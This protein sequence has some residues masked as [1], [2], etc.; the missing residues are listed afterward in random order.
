MT[1]WNPPVVSKDMDT[2]QL[3]NLVAELIDDV[4]FIMNGNIDSRNTREIGGY[5]VG[6]H[7]LMSKNGE[8]GLS[9]I[10][11]SADDIRIWA[12]S[13]IPEA[14]P[15]RVYESGRMEATNGYFTGDI[16]GST[17]TGSLIQTQPAGNYPRAGL[18]VVDNL[19]FAESSPFQYILMRASYTDNIPY[20]SF[21]DGVYNTQ[22]RQHSTTFVM[23][24][25]NV[26][27]IY[28]EDR[29]VLTPVND[30]ELAPFSGDVTVPSWSRLYNRSTNRNLQ[31][32]L[33]SLSSRISA[34]GG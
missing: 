18:S 12:G 1:I 15:F 21:Y 28:P 27:Q 30:L 16:V 34:L 6:L 7:E 31:Q 32:E 5:M 10:E 20:L 13:S 4:S 14:A 11:T 19:F 25:T 33:N 2:K 8:V 17:I 24:S 23:G 3:A 22:L 9:S 29:L 26:I